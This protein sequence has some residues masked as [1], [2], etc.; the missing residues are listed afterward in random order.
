M[1]EDQNLP[2][3]VIMTKVEAQYG[4]YG[5]NNFYKMQVK[6]IYL[7]I[8]LFIYFHKTSKKGEDKKIYKNNIK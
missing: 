5:M 1:D 6:I 4:R 3:D 7:F 8:Y 2:Y